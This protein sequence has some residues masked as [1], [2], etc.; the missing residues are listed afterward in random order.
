[1]GSLTQASLANSG[2]RTL[3]STPKRSTNRHPF[4]EDWSIQNF[5][6]ADRTAWVSEQKPLVRFYPHP[7]WLNGF[8]QLYRLTVN[9]LKQLVQLQHEIRA[10]I[11]VQFPGAFG[12]LGPAE[13]PRIDA[14]KVPWGPH[15]RA[16]KTVQ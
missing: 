10:I 7:S 12:P 15:R 8:L 14:P 3:R 1:M 2:G 4:A 13:R 5:S 6:E 16:A 9:L 11:G